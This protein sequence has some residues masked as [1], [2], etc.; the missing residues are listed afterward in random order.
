MAT[1]WP[2]GI[3]PRNISFAIQNVSRSGGV[4]TNGQEQIVGSG[5]GRWMAQLAGI[6]IKDDDAILT[7]R[8]FHI[9]L[10]GRAGTVL[11]PAFD[12]FRA[13]WPKDAYGRTLDPTFTRRR[14]LD[15]TQFED[16]EIPTQSQVNATFAAPA[17]RRATTVQI[18]V[19]QGTPI[20][21]GQYFSPSAG[22]L[23]LVTSLINATTFTI[24]PPLRDAVTLGQ[25]VDFTRPT[26]EM[27]LMS[28]DDGR[29][30]LEVARWGFVD[31][32][33]VESV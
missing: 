22:R 21:A 28:D 20:K 25:S 27:R 6:P 9:G 12:W 15:G 23:H 24:E 5:A 3:Y 10:R 33:F 31:L 8:A 4:S 2:A 32:S 13:N 14:Q 7:W 29:L 17:A 18:T 1:A 11:V 19:S 16:P 30:G 26:C